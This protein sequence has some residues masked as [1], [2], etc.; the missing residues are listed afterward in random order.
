VDEPVSRA[1]VQF[2]STSPGGRAT[3]SLLGDGGVRVRFDSRQRALC[4]GQGAVF[5]R[6]D[7]VLGSGVIARVGRPPEP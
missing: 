5:Y 7:E 6:R 4:P 1:R 2:R 3:L